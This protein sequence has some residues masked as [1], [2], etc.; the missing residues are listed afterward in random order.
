M[1]V[2]FTNCKTLQKCSQENSG[3]EI[4][5]FR[6]SILVVR[7]EFLTKKLLICLLK[8]LQN[9]VKNIKQIEKQDVFT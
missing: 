5:E 4:V 1:K 9:E 2:T 8:R 3:K 7:H 6:N